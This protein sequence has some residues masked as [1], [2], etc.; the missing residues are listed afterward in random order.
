[1]VTLVEETGAGLANANTYASVAYADAYFESHPFYS[2]NWAEILSADKAILLAAATRL[3][4]SMY[5][6]YGYRSTQT[7]GLDWPRRGVRDTYDYLLPLGTVPDR[8]RQATAEQAFWLTKGDKSTEAQTSTGLDK[9]RIDVIELDFSSS[10]STKSSTQPV[11][12]SVRTLLR[13]LGDYSGGM[14]VRRV[15]VG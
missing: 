14:R 4:D 1:M 6:W 12:S 5:Q 3:L 9:L 11:V 8:L 15:V 10:T 7:Q 2:D 13:G